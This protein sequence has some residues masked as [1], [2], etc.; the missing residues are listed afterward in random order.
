VGISE[1]LSRQILYLLLSCFA[2]Q[3]AQPTTRTPLTSAFPLME[4]DLIRLLAICRITMPRWETGTS[5]ELLSAA[6]RF[7]ADCELHSSESSVFLR[8]FMRWLCKY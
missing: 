7:C 5:P 1:A 8:L 4:N 3:L 2:D 6:R